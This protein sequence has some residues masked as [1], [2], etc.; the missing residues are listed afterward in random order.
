MAT[1]HVASG[2]GSKRSIVVVVSIIVFII[3]L[4][5]V[6]RFI[7]SRLREFFGFKVDA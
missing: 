1:N 4:N 2:N 5:I 6:A 7:A 3:V